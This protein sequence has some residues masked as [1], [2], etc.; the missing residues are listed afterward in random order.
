MIDVLE[1]SVVGLTVLNG[2]P[3]MFYFGTTQSIQFSNCSF[4][5]GNVRHNHYPYN[6]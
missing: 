5:G 1:F 2:S 6:N 3:F 4:I